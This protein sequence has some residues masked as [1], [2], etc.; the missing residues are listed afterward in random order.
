LPYNIVVCV[1]QVPDTTDVKID[2]ETKTLVREGVPSIVNPFDTYALEE[3][4]RIRERAGGK[5]TVLSMGPPQA[6]E[7]L[8][9]C[10]AVGADETMLLT[11]RAFAGADTLATAYALSLA[12]GKL[13]ADIVLCG[14]QAWDG[15]TAQVGPGVAEELDIPHATYVRKITLDGDCAIV[16]RLVEGGYEIVKVPLPALFTVVK[17][18][19]EPRL[20]SLRGKMRAKNAKIPTW[21]PQDIGADTSRLGLAGSPTEVV[22]VFSPE[23]RKRGE[24]RELPAPEAAQY[25]LSKLEGVIR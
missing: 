7:A 5:V 4:I 8:K 20:P 1:K 15:D 3:A 22:R 25:L 21:G 17:E 11:D 10:L 2:P 6:A 24:V 16:E 9:E 12:I 18:I 19:N 23:A 14:K 13:G